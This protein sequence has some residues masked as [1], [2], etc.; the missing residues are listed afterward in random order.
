[1]RPAFST[2][3]IWLTAS[4]TLSMMSRRDPPLLRG[5]DDG[6]IGADDIDEILV[7]IG[8][9]CSISHYLNVK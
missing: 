4:G 3:K 5:D 9:K 7:F 8:P 1:L 6:V 2:W